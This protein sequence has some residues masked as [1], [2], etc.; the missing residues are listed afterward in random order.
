MHGLCKSFVYRKFCCLQAEKETGQ[1]LLCSQ[2]YVL[3]G[4][5]QPHIE[6]A[7]YMALNK[8]PYVLRKKTGEGKEKE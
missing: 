3:W 8:T 5:I 1:D 7:D 4:F 6:T 2:R